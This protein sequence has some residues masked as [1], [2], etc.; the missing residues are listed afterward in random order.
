[1]PRSEKLNR[2]LAPTSSSGSKPIAA[3]TGAAGLELT[4]RRA[5]CATTQIEQEERSLVVG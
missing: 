5:L 1:M 4:V 2:I 3:N